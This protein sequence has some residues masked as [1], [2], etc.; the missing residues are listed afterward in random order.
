VN[1]GAN[2]SGDYVYDSSTN[3]DGFLAA[4]TRRGTIDAVDMVYGPGDAFSGAMLGGS[5]T[6]TYQRVPLAGTT[7]SLAQFPTGVVGDLSV[8]VAVSNGRPFIAY[9][10]SDKVFFRQ[11]TGGAGNENSAS[12]WSAEQQAAAGI[13]PKLAGNDNGVILGLQPRPG[14]PLQAA[15]MSGSSFGTPLTVSGTRDTTDADLFA[16]QGSGP[17]AFYMAAW[18]DIG[19]EPDE[20][21]A[22]S[23]LDGGDW[24]TPVPLVADASLTDADWGQRLRIAGNGNGSGFVTFLAGGRVYAA[25]LDQ[26]DTGSGIAPSS[27]AASAKGLVL[28]DPKGCVKPGAQVRL[29]VKGH[30]KKFKVTKVGFSLDSVKKTDTSSPFSKLFS[31]SGFTLSTKHKAKAAVSLRRIKKPHKKATQTLQ[32]TVKIC[33]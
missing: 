33:S 25:S 27:V 3:G 8:P 12:G 7:T 31:T 28:L 30:R 15:A 17:D 32:S 5:D 10:Y 22:A 9:S 29:Q 1:T 11:F 19:T 24:S 13:A 2:Q 14:G 18:R 20:V 16:I 21:R 4:T 26:V 6:P 23:S